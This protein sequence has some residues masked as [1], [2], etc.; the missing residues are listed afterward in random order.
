[1]GLGMYAYACVHVCVCVH[2]HHTLC[3]DQSLLMYC[4]GNN[5]EN[6][7]QLKPHQ[8]MFLYYN[9]SNSH[10]YLNCKS[11]IR[12]SHKISN[13][14]Y[15]C[16]CNVYVCVCVRVCLF[17]RMCNVC[18]CLVYTTISCHYIQLVTMPTGIKQPRNDSDKLAGLHDYMS[19]QHQSNFNN[20]SFN[21]ATN[22]QGFELQPQQPYALD[23]SYQQ[24]LFPMITNQLDQRF[25]FQG[26]PSLNNEISKHQ[27]GQQMEFDN[28]V[29]KVHKIK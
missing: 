27:G 13:K 10:S 23:M 25:V 20:S 29:A 9:S 3:M 18:V 19:S 14:R 16:D 24:P 2:L 15:A 6:K 28:Q 5:S 12:N 4:A 21:K 11:K 7:L 17:V 22:F 26:M 8:L 1:M